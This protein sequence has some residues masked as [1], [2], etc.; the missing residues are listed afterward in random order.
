MSA[1]LVARGLRQADVAR[2]R[3]LALLD[4]LDRGIAR[5]GL[6]LPSLMASPPAVGAPSTA[7]TIAGSRLYSVAVAADVARFN[8]EGGD[9]ALAGTG[10]PLN[11][12]YQCTS[13]HSG[14]GTDP[15]A[16]PSGN[17]GRV[18]FSSFAPALEF[19]IGYGDAG[20][21]FRLKVDGEY[22]QVGTLGTTADGSGTA[23]GA[24]RFI[25]LTWG[26]GSVAQRRLR[27]YE[28]EFTSNGRF[29]GVACSPLY[30]PIAQ[31][32]PDR[33]RLLV[34]GDSMVDTI[35]DTGSSA[36]ALHPV[37]G[38]LLGVLLGQPD[39]RLSNSGGTGWFGSV[40]GTKSTFNQR[41]AIDV[42]APA[43]DVIIELGG[44]NDQGLVSQPVMEAAV[45][46]WLRQ[47]L[48]A[49]PETLVFMTGPIVS[50]T[51]DNSLAGFLMVRDA[52]KAVAA[53]YPSNVVF[54][55]NLA[56]GWA[57]GSGKQTALSGDG[58]ADW[59]IGSD[60]VHPTIEGHHQLAVAIANGVAAATARLR[61]A[62]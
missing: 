57:T 22:V 4:R 21:G 29:G 50:H 1:D 8:F 46:E 56:G 55:D 32:M 49:K 45:T 37:M 26:D 42:V 39:C 43:P 54:I 20:G 23:N 40:G 2:S 35:V 31:A 27:Q 13:R 51:S 58:N 5:A 7:S 41:V 18:R 52:K 36:T 47:V 12:L 44:R 33:L 53:R 14:N 59:V 17:G 48:T 61:A 10:F 28:L 19:K 11:E 24:L 30:E 16:N 34:N 6:R 60:N 9:W 15:S 62:Q 38:T 3:R 25:K